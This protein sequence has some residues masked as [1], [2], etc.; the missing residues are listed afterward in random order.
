VLYI[1]PTK[2]KIISFV[3]NKLHNIYTAQLNKYNAHTHNIHVLRYMRFWQRYC[4]RLKYSGMLTPCCLVFVNCLTLKE[5][6][7]RSFDE[8][9]L[10]TSLNGV[11]CQKNSHLQHNFISLS[12]KHK[13]YF[14]YGINIKLYVNFWLLSA[15]W[16][17]ITQKIYDEECGEHIIVMTVVSR[18]C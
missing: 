5:Q 2:F 11:T 18:R 4:C 16:I 14:H 17:L 8:G 13:I 12:I 9:Q 15:S 3:C 1:F 10:F 6:T 7:L